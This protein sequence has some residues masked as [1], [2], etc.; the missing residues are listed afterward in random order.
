METPIIYF[1]APIGW[2]P[3]RLMVKGV[4]SQIVFGRVVAVKNNHF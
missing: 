1:I 2:M 4:F 3:L